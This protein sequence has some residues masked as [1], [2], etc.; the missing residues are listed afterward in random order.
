VHA[1]MQLPPSTGRE[2][3]VAKIATARVRAGYLPGD[4]ALVAARSIGD[5]RERSWAM[6]ALADTLTKRGDVPAALRVVSELAD[7]RGRVLARWALAPVQA[8]HGDVTGALA[9]LAGITDESRQ[10][11]AAR[12]I[13]AAQA[14][15]GQ[16]V[17]AVA[18]ASRETSSLV[19]SHALLGVAEGIL[20]KDAK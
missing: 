15:G 9:T 7:E 17:E 20:G 8:R 14:Q 4:E 16:A 10:A 2:A 11:D 6:A 12:Q 1:P 13:A 5:P 19:K 3:L 18:W